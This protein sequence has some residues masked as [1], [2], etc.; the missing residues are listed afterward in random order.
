MLHLYIDYKKKYLCKD[1]TSL[2]FRCHARNMDIHF[3]LLFDPYRLRLQCV[4][5]SMTA[6]INDSLYGIQIIP[7]EKFVLFIQRFY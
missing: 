6:D 3:C 2:V 1:N 5:I 4:K 7:M